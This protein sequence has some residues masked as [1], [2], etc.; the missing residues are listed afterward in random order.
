[1]TSMRSAVILRHPVMNRRVQFVLP[2]PS[3][4]VIKL[5]RPGA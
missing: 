1:V 5:R 4:N 2:P 3:D